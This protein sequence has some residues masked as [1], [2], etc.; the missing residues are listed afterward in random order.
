[1]IDQQDKNQMSK[2]NAKQLL[3]A[4]IQQEKATQNK[5]K[6]AQAQPRSRRFE[7]NW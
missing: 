3:N 7:K 5:I 1:M 6:K 2:D 4:A